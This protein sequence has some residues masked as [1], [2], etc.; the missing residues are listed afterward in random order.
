MSVTWT[1]SAGVTLFRIWLRARRP[2][3]AAVLR[4]AHQLADRLATDPV[5]AD[6]PFRGTWRAAR[7]G[8][9][10]VL[11]QLDAAGGAVVHHAARVVR[12]V[13]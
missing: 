7:V 3:R 10:A 2:D 8:P 9:V 6:P 5:R 4:A 13:G 12:A 11:Y 1:H